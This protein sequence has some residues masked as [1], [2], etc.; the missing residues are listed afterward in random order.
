MTANPFTNRVPVV[1]GEFYDRERELKLLM[2]RISTPVPQ[3]VSIVAPQR[4]GTSSFLRQ[5]C[6]IVGP[7]QKPQW[8]YKYVD[9]LGVGSRDDFCHVLCQTL[10]RS[11]NTIAMAR[12]AVAKLKNRTIVVLDGLEHLLTKPAEFNPDFFGFLRSIASGTQLV[13]VVSTTRPLK[14]LDIPWASSPTSAFYNIF[15]VIKLEPWTEDICCQFL[16]ERSKAAGRPFSEKEVKSIVSHTNGQTPYHLQ[17]LADHCWSARV[18]D[19]VR[20]AKVLKAYHEEID[21]PKRKSNPKPRLRLFG[22][23]RI[24]N[25]VIIA[26]SIAV[27]G[28]WL[29]FG[30]HSTNT[31]L[32]CEDPS[33]P[34]QYE[35]VLDFPQYL[36]IGDTGQLE[37]TVYNKT[38]KTQSLAVVVGFDQPI[39]MIGAASSRIDFKELANEERRSAQIA[40]HRSNHENIVLAASLQISTTT[41]VC[42]PSA[43]KSSPTILNGPIPYLTQVWAW[44]GAAAGPLAF[45]ALVATDRLKK[46]GDK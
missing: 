28:L 5:F 2:E 10:G 29:T 3:P 13:L 39:Q 27:I 19:K 44:L 6:T 23:S 14:E 25:L 17:V 46:R 34:E 15:R 1:G 21:S 12:D 32:L 26:I 18:S 37:L 33:I 43:A 9:L 4:M 42:N 31:T 36:A 11:G 8:K 24:F 30:I 40:F 7:K 35:L 45:V 41:V 20:W 22:A 38:D 16:L